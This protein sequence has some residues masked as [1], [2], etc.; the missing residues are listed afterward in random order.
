MVSVCRGGQGECA[1]TVIGKGHDGYVYGML[2]D[3]NVGVSIV[4]ISRVRKR[5]SVSL[6]HCQ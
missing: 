2:G 6:R 3:G 5:G 1:S 4:E